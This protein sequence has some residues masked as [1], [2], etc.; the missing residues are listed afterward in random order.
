MMA[1]GPGTRCRFS[2]GFSRISRM[3]CTT[4]VCEA[5]EAGGVLRARERACKAITSSEAASRKRLSHFLTQPS[6]LFRAVASSWRVQSGCCCASQCKLARLTINWASVSKS[7][8]SSL[9]SGFPQVYPRRGWQKRR[10]LPNRE[11][12]ARGERQ[13]VPEKQIETFETEYIYYTALSRSI[14]I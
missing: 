6:D 1:S 2:G 8:T 11:Q 3:R 7:L 5:M 9:G 12:K 10:S 4:S 14:Y 13:K